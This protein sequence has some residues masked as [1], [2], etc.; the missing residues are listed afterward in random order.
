MGKSYYYIAHSPGEFL[1]EAASLTADML[2]N[3]SS[4]YTIFRDCTLSSENGFH[5]SWAKTLRTFK[6][7]SFSPSAS[8]TDQIIN[9]LDTVDFHEIRWKFLTHLEE[10][11]EVDI[12]RYIGGH[13]R[14]WNGVKRMRRMRH[15]VRI[16]I[17][18][19][20]NAVRSSS[21]LAVAGAVGVTFAE[22]MESMG[23]SSEIWAV[24]CSLE[25]DMN[26]NHYINLVRLK[27]Q[28]EYADMGLVGWFLGN[29]GVFRNALFRQHILS[30]AKKGLD[31]HMGLGHST[32]IHLSQIGLTSEEQRSSILV[33]SLFS[34]EEA[35]E[36]LS[37]ALSDQN[38]LHDIIYQDSGDINERQ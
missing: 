4:G 6:E 1:K 19:G 22:L 28:N 32:S 13:E 30:A 36:W 18:F 3:D 21:E 2:K 20:G 11:D 25:V 24:H 14:C 10:G 37:K 16:Y 31:V 9:E 15:S 35:S 7:S 34:I 33:P 5:G 29:D 17:N 8:L 27:A 12:E 26:D 38:I 23:L